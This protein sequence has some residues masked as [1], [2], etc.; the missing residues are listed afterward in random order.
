MHGDVISKVRQFVIS[1]LFMTVAVSATAADTDQKLDRALQQLVEAQT[2]TA[3][4]VIISGT[5][6]CLAAVGRG[7]AAHGDRVTD[8]RS[9]NAVAAV[10]HGHD[11]PGLGDIGCVSGVSSDAVVTA[12]SGITVMKK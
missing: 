9:S 8:L 11:L 4:R 6:S 3:Q 5:A 12:R 10:V 2:H 7:L 1:L